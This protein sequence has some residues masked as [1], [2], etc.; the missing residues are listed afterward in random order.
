MSRPALSGERCSS[1]GLLALGRGPARLLSNVGGQDEERLSIERSESSRLVEDR[2]Q[3][4]EL[5]VI[6]PELSR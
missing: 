2:A 5:M 1:S 3:L 4:E 6:G